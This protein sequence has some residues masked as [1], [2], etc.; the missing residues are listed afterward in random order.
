MSPRKGGKVGQLIDWWH[1]RG[2]TGVVAKTFTQWLAQVADDFE[3]DEFS[4]DD[5]SRHVVRT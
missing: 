2:A 5:E 1:E 4:Y 3:A